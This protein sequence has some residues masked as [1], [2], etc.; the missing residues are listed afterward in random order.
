MN[1]PVKKQAGILKMAGG[2]QI[3]SLVKVDNKN[4]LKLS[5]NYYIIAGVKKANG[6]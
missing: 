5:H 4:Y 3:I 2:L 6:I 1:Y